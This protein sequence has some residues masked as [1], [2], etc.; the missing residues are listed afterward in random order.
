MPILTF[1]S[2]SF[3]VQYGDHLRFWDCL[4]TLAH[5]FGSWDHLQAGI[6]CGKG[7]FAGRDH[8][9]SVPICGPGGRFSKAPE[10]FRARKA[11]ANLEPSNYKVALFAYSKDEGRSLHTRSFRLVHFSVFRYRWSKN[12]FTGPKSFRGL[13]GTGPC[14][15]Q[16]KGLEMRLVVIDFINFPT[17]NRVISVSGGQTPRSL[18]NHWPRKPGHEVVL[19]N[20]ERRNG[21]EVGL[22]VGEENILNE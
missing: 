10:T 12:G 15:G 19:F 3:A 9:Q 14:A 7:S 8:L 2:G 22:Q 21:C 13:R 11:I 20:K 6:I 1:W 17:G 4:R 16:M 18:L 5:W